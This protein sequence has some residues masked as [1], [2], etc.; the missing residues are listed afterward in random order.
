[1]AHALVFDA[2]EWKRAGYDQ[3][4]GNE[5]FW[6]RAKTVRTYERNGDKLADVRFDHDGRISHGHFMRSMRE[7]VET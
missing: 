6:H 7:V 3:P 1:M 4:D 5:Q 2:D